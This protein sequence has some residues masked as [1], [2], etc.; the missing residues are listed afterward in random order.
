MSERAPSKGSES[1][2]ERKAVKASTLEMT[3]IQP[4]SGLGC[5]GAR[6]EE[7]VERIL[8]GGLCTCKVPEANKCLECSWN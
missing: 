6:N 2:L 8:A 5:D 7:W 3:R 1:L 4:G